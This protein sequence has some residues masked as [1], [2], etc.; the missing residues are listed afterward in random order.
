MSIGIAQRSRSKVVFP[1]PHGD[2]DLRS[3]RLQPDISVHCDQ[4]ASA[5]HVPGY[6]PA[7]AGTHCAYPRMADQ[8][9]LTW[10]TGYI[11]RYHIISYPRDSYPHKY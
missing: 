1:E 10:V 3:F 2:A 9:E 4:V 11:P 7:F 6:S 5:W 8:V